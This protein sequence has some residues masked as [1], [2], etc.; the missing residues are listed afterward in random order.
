M[1]VH[2]DSGTIPAYTVSDV[3]VVLVNEIVASVS[4]STIGNYLDGHL[5]GE[6]LLKREKIAIVSDWTPEKCDY[7]AEQSLKNFL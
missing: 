4:T 7:N 6:Y 3:S 1:D 5:A 2:P